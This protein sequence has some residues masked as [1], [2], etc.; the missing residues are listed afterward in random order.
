MAWGGD[1]LLQEGG[2]EAP[3]RVQLIGG[4]KKCGTSPGR[5]RHPHPTPPCGGAAQPLTCVQGSKNYLTRAL[6]MCHLCHAQEAPCANAKHGKR[7]CA[8]HQLAIAPSNRDVVIKRTAGKRGC[9][10]H[11]VCVWGGEGG[12]GGGEEGEG[13]VVVVLTRASQRTRL[14]WLAER[15][16]YEGRVPAHIT[17]KAL[18]LCPGPH[19]TTPGLLPSAMLN[20]VICCTSSFA[21]TAAEARG[22]GSK[23]LRIITPF[24]FSKST[25]ASAK[26]GQLLLVEMYSCLA[27]PLTGRP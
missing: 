27:C 13:V 11:Q 25:V 18:H 24:S 8:D 10:V 15:C 3:A 16:T 5:L 4:F 20:L 21:R 19:A 7:E 26:L 22:A 1:D 17:S 14:S 6:S 2:E 23:C 12:R 9:V